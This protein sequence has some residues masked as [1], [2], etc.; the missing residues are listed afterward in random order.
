MS[1]Q[2]VVRK[3]VKIYNEST[4]YAF[5]ALNEVSFEIQKGD[6]V[7][8]VGPNGSGKTTLLNL[9]GVMDVTS[10]GYIKI[11][12]IN[13]MLIA[14]DHT[15]FKKKV[16]IGYLLQ[17]DYLIE[18]MKVKDNLEI[19]LLLTGKR[20]ANAAERQLAYFG[21]EDCLNKYPYQ[22]S[23]GQ[24]LKVSLLRSLINSPE[25]LVADEPTG[26]LDEESGQEVMRLLK[27][28]QEE[29]ATTVIVV[30]HDIRVAVCSDYCLFINEGKICE[31]VESGA[32]YH[33]RIK[34][35]YDRIDEKRFV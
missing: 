4:P 27:K 23:V 24:R 2:I 28:Y 29:N 30:T 9:L 7:A 11:N 14:L 1:E 18:E 3:A 21:L 12:D 10:S 8:I 5:K 6:F 22:L 35:A 34:A 31:R 16:R 26:N 32:D 17:E 33:N 19:P 13:T 15:S 20:T 25:V